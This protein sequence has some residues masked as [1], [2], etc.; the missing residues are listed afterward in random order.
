MITAAVTVDDLGEQPPDPVAVRGSV[1]GMG[2]SQIAL[3]QP[4]DSGAVRVHRG[5]AAAEI[6]GQSTVGP[7]KLR[8][9]PRRSGSTQQRPQR[10]R[11]LAGRRATQ[12]G[13]AAVRLSRNR[14]GDE[15][16]LLLT[17]ASGALKTRALPA[18][19]QFGGA[20]CDRCRGETESVEDLGR[21]E[22]ER[23]DALVRAIRVDTAFNSVD[24]R[25][26]DDRLPMRGLRGSSGG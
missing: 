24:R 17:L 6:K 20:T 19:V 12:V 4:A 7:G 2:Q 26:S 25:L 3:A 18:A 11:R 21:G 9:Q 5:D 14:A 10:Q 16:H 13:N 15:P 22:S 1:R 23:L 8:L